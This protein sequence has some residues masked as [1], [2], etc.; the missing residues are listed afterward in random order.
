[1]GRTGPPPKPPKL[2]KVQRADRDRPHVHAPPGV[3]SCPPE[4]DDVARRIWNEVTPALLE[5]G[6]LSPIDGG[7]LAGY[8]MTLATALKLSESAAKAPMLGTAPQ[9]LNPAAA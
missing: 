8:C 5:I 4:L 2:R 9:W 1:M 6:T 7:M 3:P